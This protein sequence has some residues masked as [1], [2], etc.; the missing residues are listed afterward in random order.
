MIAV[1]GVNLVIQIDK[2]KYIIIIII[3]QV[4]QV[5]THYVI[6]TGYGHGSQAINQFVLPI[7]ILMVN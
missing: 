7:T 3:I 1:W 4:I 5:H 6:E 2:L